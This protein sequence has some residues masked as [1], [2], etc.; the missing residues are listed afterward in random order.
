MEVEI[1]AAVVEEQTERDA[2]EAALLRGFLAEIPELVYFK[3]VDSRIL[4]ASESLE[5]PARA[6]GISTVHAVAAQRQA[7][8]AWN[9]SPYQTSVP[10]RHQTQE[11]PHTL[12]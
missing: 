3:D 7:S 10:S 5:A 8:R 4:A 9:P 6:H 1:E 2:R 11:V 12:A